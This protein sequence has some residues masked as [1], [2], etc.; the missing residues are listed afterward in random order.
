LEK[1]YS[2][3]KSFANYC[4]VTR[5]LQSDILSGSKKSTLIYRKTKMNSIAPLYNQKEGKNSE[6]QKDYL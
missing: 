1:K 5:D 4:V 2:F 6:S 3:E